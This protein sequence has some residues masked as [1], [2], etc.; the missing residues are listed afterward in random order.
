MSAEGHK[1]D[2]KANLAVEGYLKEHAGELRGTVSKFIYEIHESLA[3]FGKHLNPMEGD[4]SEVK[5]DVAL[6]RKI[7][8][9]IRQRLEELNG[10]KFGKTE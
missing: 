6:A 7:E 10:L 2:A 5:R 9:E 3:E 4:S 8:E 1:S